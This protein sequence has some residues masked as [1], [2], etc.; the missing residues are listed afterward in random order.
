MQWNSLGLNPGNKVGEDKGREKVRLPLDPLK[1]LQAAEARM[2]EGG[3]T[4]RMTRS[5]TPSARPRIDRLAHE[6]P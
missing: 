6:G 3:R 4:Q 2:M 5:H 1:D